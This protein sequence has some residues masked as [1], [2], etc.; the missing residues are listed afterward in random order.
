MVRKVPEGKKKS[1]EVPQRRAPYGY[2][3]KRSETVRNAPKWSYSE[4]QRFDG[5]GPGSWELGP[6]SWGPESFKTLAKWASRISWLLDR[7]GPR[8][9]YCQQ[10][11]GFGAP[12]TFR[13][14]AFAQ[15]GIRIRKLSQKQHSAVA[16]AARLQ[17]A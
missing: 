9:L 6:G 13:P 15:T 2:G 5:W 4:S 14:G 16:R 1:R 3:P 8:P 17:E 10:S 7:R 11:Q 12:F